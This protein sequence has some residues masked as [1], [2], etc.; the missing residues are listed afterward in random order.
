VVPKDDAVEIYYHLH[1]GIEC[2]NVQ[3]SIGHSPNGSGHGK[4][5]PLV[6]DSPKIQYHSHKLHWTANPHSIMMVCQVKQDIIYYRNH[7]PRA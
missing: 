5:A 7:R 2:C 3:M 6:E 1:P 4:Q